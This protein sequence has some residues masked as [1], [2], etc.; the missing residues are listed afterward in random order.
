MFAPYNFK[1]PLLEEH[2]KL[3]NLLGE[4]KDDEGKV[5][6]K[7]NRW[8]EVHDFTKK[9]DG[10]L[11]YKLMDKDEFKIKTVGELPDMAD[12]DFKGF[13]SD[14]IFELPKQFGGSLI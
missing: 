1:Y 13:E 9:A 6:Q 8:N 5:C 14:F 4:Y 11:N 2:S 12:I 7:Y 3:A 10:T